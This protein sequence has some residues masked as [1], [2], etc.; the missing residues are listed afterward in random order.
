MLNAT[1]RFDLFNQFKC[2]CAADPFIER[3]GAVLHAAGLGIMGDVEIAVSERMDAGVGVV[4]IPAA[5]AGGGVLAPHGGKRQYQPLF[6]R[7]LTD[8]IAFIRN[9]R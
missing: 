3:G 4:E 5:D 6:G 1:A 9:Y 7:R 2:F 8:Y